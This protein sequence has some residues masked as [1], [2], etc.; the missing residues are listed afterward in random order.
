MILVFIVTPGQGF[1]TSLLNL[2]RIKPMHDQPS[3]ATDRGWHFNVAQ[4]LSWLPK[5]SAFVREMAIDCK[6]H[7]ISLFSQAQC[8]AADR[9][10]GKRTNTKWLG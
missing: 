1:G 4:N 8:L 10:S 9:P 6:V 7:P 2:L 5:V 3:F